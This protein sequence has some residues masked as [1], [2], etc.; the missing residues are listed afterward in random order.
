MS[1]TK[2][3]GALMLTAFFV[4]IFY[5]LTK[6]IGLRAAINTF[7]LAIAATAFLVVAVK[8]YIGSAA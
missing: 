3:L 4:V 1:P 7:A 5:I 2:L 6:D 8:F